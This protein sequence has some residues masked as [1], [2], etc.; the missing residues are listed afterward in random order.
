MKTYTKSQY[1]A[2]PKSYKGKNSNGQKM[3]LYFENGGT[4]W[5]PVE[6]VKG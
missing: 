4:V 2:L 3:A 1:A 6:I 5:G